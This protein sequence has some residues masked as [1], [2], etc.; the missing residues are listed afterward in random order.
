MENLIISFNAVM[1]MFLI[2]ALGSVLRWKKMMSEH[3]QGQLNNL[4]FRV[5]IP[6]LLING[7]YNTDLRQVFQ[8]KLIV[9]T[10][11][12]IL[13]MWLCATALVMKIDKRPQKRGA[14]IQAI[15]RSNY[16]LFGL[17]ILGNLYGADSI[18]I[19][20]LLVAVVL[21]PFNALAVITLQV[22]CGRKVE[23]K[24]ILIEVAK[25]PFIIAVA[26]GIVISYLQLQLPVFIESTLSSVSGMAMPV[27]L[28]AM[29][30]SLN[31]EKTFQDHKNLSIAVIGKLVVVPLIFVPITVLFGFRGIE[32]ASLMAIFASPTAVV[33]YVMAD[34]MN[35]DAELASAAIILSTVIS[36]FTMF[37]WIFILKQLGLI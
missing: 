34:Q 10:M 5:F 11:V 8:L 31:L 36:C 24:E 30:A 18:G 15:C 16:T 9:F 32:L 29:G 21:P 12:S 13:I 1:P 35:S 33:S 4:A 7:I 3:T 37:L 27:A 6:F 22:F 28:V 19:P 2:M 14:M 25:N 23:I 20:S 17:A 26:T